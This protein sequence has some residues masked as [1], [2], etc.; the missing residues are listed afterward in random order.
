MIIPFITIR[1]DYQRDKGSLSFTPLTNPPR[2]AILQVYSRENPL[3]DA[4][5]NGWTNYET[6]NVALYIQ[7]EEPV[8]RH[9]VRLGQWGYDDMIPWLEGYFGQCTPD[10]VR[11]MDP[12][13]DTDEL[14]EMLAECA[15]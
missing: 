8:Y 11:F 9:A 14:D 3:T 7:N 4:T 1:G 15:S 12:K 13:L 5:F 2:H 10:G 6:W